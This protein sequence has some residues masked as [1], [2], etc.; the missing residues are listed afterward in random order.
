MTRNDPS[1]FERAQQGDLEARNQLIE[2]NLGLCW[3]MASYIPWRTPSVSTEDLV[4]S[5][6]LG[7]V[8]A[9]MR[10]DPHRGTRFSH[11]AGFHILRA[12]QEAVFQGAWGI[13]R[14]RSYFEYIGKIKK[15]AEK[16]AKE[17]GRE[18]SVG[19]IHA[20]FAGDP[21]VTRE[22]VAEIV[23]GAYVVASLDARV[24]D[25][26]ECLH[27]DAI[28]DESARFDH[29]IELR[30]ALAPVLA[31]LPDEQRELL[32]EHYGLDGGA[33]QSCRQIGKRNGI[34]RQ[35]AH[36]RIR[37]AL[38]AAREKL[39]DGNTTCVADYLR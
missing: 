33:P 18:P 32:T 6:I 25:T 3:R 10:F 13:A 12:M 34:S 17:L 37:T 26:E 30:L 2:A 36:Q 4:Q 39:L 20:S 16:L 8:E 14:T 21:C 9:I 7:L 15:R 24:K 5:G 29:R 28:A 23:N 35:A 19:E 38:K 27:L 22:L 31:A 11:Y 1:L